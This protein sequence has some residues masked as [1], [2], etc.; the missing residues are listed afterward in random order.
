[1]TDEAVFPRTVR[2]W[3]G[4]SYA[5]YLVLPRAVMQSMPEEWQAKMVALLDECGDRLGH[6]Y[7]ANEYRVR[8]V[9]GGRLAADPLADYRHQ[10]L[11]PKE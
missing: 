8:L 11:D 5:G 2:E 3:F 9:E 1:M 4:L 6:H 10:R 7:G